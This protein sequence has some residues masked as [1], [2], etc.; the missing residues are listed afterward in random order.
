MLGLLYVSIHPIH[1]IVLWGR[2][3]I[4]IPI[5]QGLSKG[6]KTTELEK[7][8]SPKTHLCLVGEGGGGEKKSK[9]KKLSVAG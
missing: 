8:S 9:Q 2:F 1:K 3:S 4:V 5:L 7:P 6:P